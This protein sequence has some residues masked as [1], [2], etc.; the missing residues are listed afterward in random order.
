LV[1]LF[2]VPLTIFSFGH[3][4]L[5]LILGCAFLGMMGILC[6]ILSETFDQMSAMTSYVITPL[7]FLSG[8]FYSTNSLPGFWQKLAHLNPIFYMIDGFRYG[9]TGYHDSNLNIGIIYLVSINL[10]LAGSLIMMLRKGYKIT[11]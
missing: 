8:T 3:L 11:H 5:F 1:I 7:T 9:M 10:I 6:G 2:F 4:L